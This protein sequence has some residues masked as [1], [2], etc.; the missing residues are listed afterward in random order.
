MFW[1]GT[2]IPLPLEAVSTV[3]LLAPAGEMVNKLLAADVKSVLDAVR[4]LDPIKSIFKSLNVASPP[5]SVSFCRVPLK[6]P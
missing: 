6:V 1:S 5:V 3:I 4:T 2:I